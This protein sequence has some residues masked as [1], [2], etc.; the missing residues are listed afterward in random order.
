MWKEVVMDLV[1]YPDIYLEGLRKTTKKFLDSNLNP[2]PPEQEA[3][4]LPS[5]S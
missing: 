5:H 2:G 1:Y 3:E 4:M